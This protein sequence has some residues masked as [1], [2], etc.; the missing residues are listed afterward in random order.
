MSQEGYLVALERQHEQLKKELSKER[1]RSPWN[2]LE[3]A[4]IKRKKLQIK[5]EIA[6][7]RREQ[8]MFLTLCSEIQRMQAKSVAL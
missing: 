2:D 7:A 3:L 8:A 5:D 1:N 4:A 6:A